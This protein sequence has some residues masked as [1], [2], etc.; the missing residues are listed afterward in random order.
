[1]YHCGWPA[2]RCRQIPFDNTSK[3]SAGPCAGTERP[4]GPLLASAVRGWEGWSA[5]GAAA[6]SA[7]RRQRGVSSRAARAGCRLV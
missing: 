3:C 4:L 2:A 6:R 7:P 1:M 5:P